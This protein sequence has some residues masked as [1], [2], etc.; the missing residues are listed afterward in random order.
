[1][2]QTASMRVL[3]W[4]GDSYGRIPGGHRV[5]MDETRKALVELGIDVRVSLDPDDDFR[6]TDVVHGMGLTRAS[7]R[8]VRRAGL[9]LAVSTIYAGLRYTL[10]NQTTRSWT[11][12]AERVGRLTWSLVRR[13]EYATASNLVAPLTEKRLAF[14][15]ADLLLP[16]SPSEAAAIRDELHVT[17]PSHVVPNGVNHHTFVPPSAGSKRRGVLY[18]GRLDPHKNQL[19][20][21]RALEGS[22]IPLTIAG[23]THPHHAE[24]AAACR[25]AAGPDVHF[26]DG[27]SQAGLVE[28]YQ[29]ALVHAMP[30]WFET[31]GL[32]SLEAALCDTAVVTTGHGFARDYF[33]DMVHYCDPS[34]LRSIR[35]AVETALSSDRSSHLRDHV[36][37]HYTW[38]HAAAATSVA[39]E[40]LLP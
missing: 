39:Y 32:T 28:L 2:L 27:R 19:G 29:Q 13:G 22:G 1:M 40:Q 36:L 16:N 4:L 12:K 23:P 7:M 37:G 21:I 26:V 17:T 20:L 6:G 11:A 35:A 15:C 38:E 24:Y 33:G 30:S 31:T 8:R 10:G 34:S 5:Q 18:V 14:E 9:P 3:L 25:A